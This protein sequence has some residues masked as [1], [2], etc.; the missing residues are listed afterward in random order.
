MHFVLITWWQFICA[1]LLLLTPVALLEGR[2]VHFREI[3]RDWDRHWGQITSLWI[4]YFD[5]AR[6]ALGTWLLMESLHPVDNPHGLAKYAPILIHGGV[7]VIAIFV[8]SVWCKS[9]DSVNAPFAFVAGA[10][11][12]GVSPLAG[13]VALALAI[14]LSAGS[15]TPAA[16]FPVV[17]IVFLAAAFLFGGKGMII[18]VALAAVAPLIPW[19]WSLL[20]H[21][22]LVLPYLSAHRTG[23]TTP[24]LAATQR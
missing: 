17:M 6:A 22:S 5:F 7:Q 12:G 19:L 9:P 24:P 21:R 8:Q 3:D 14:P 18:K 15:R 13:T 2:R 1:L 23:R 20:F 4:H 16:F 10:L 11:L